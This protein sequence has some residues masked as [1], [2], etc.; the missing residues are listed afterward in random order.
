MNRLI[1]GI[2]A[3]FVAVTKLV[4]MND[5]V[6]GQ[7]HTDMINTIVTELIVVI[8]GL[9]YLMIADNLPRNG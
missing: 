5:T 7:L 4:L 9:L 3:V 8:R 6:C 1:I 2:L